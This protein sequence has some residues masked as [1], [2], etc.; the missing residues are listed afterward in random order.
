MK[1]TV[2]IL[3][4]VLVAPTYFVGL[5]MG[6]MLLSYKFDDWGLGRSWFV[7]FSEVV[8]LTTL[9]FLICAVI[10]PFAKKLTVVLAG[11][12]FLVIDIGA[13]LSDAFFLK[14]NS[15]LLDFQD[16]FSMTIADC[17]GA[18]LATVIIFWIYARPNQS[19]LR[20]CVVFFV[21]VAGGWGISCWQEYNPLTK[22]GLTYEKTFGDD[23]DFQTVAFHWNRTKKQIDGPFITDDDLYVKFKKVGHDAVPEIVVRSE[24]NKSDYAVFRLNFTDADKPDIELVESHMVVEY[25]PPW[26][27][28][29]KS[30]PDTN[31]TLPIPASD[32]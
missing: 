14:E 29:Y 28:Y 6:G 3:R 22:Y 7:S 16:C 2:A 31:E 30:D 8:L 25:P 10:A 12:V 1:E 32:K 9:V 21:L 19:V 5:L 23:D 4:W 11:L 27:D 26:S 20:V 17:L 15:A 13:T 18:G 24:T